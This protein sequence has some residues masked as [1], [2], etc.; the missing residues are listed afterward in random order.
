MGKYE[1]S[2]GNGNPKGKKRMSTGKKVLVIFVSVFFVALAAL[3]VWILQPPVQDPGKR[4]SAASSASIEPPTIGPPSS[5]D[6]SIAEPPKGDRIKGIYTILIAGTN[7]DY[8]TDTIMICYV[9][10]VKNKANVVSIPRD[11]QIDIPNSIKRINGSYGRAGMEELCAQVTTILGVPV[12]YYC[13]INLRNF[14][15]LVNLID[16]ID[17][18]VPYNMYHA[19]PNPND[20]INLKK[21]QQ[22]LNGKEALMLVRYRGSSQNDFG[23]TQVQRDFLLAVCKKLVK[24]FSVTKMTDIMP[25]IN[26][27]LKTSMT[28]TDMLWFYINFLREVDLDKDINWMSLPHESTGLYK[29]QDYVYLDPKQIVEFVNEYLNPFD[30]PITEANI[31]IPHLKDTDR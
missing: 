17:F 21:G 2:N 26:E 12:D 9:D 8:N 14:V 19:D 4:T 31:H 13:L 29:G 27:S 30:L 7:D 15:K 18:Y 24:E 10:T 5:S 3:V 6:P 22:W 23:R 25:V 20:V 1:F 16:G 11:T 28:V